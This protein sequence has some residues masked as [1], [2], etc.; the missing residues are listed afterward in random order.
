MTRWL[1]LIVI[2]SVV[3]SSPLAAQ[4]SS[5]TSGPASVEALRSLW[6]Q[7]TDYILRSAEQMPEE[8]YSYRPTEEVRSFGE[9]IAHVAGAQYTICAAALADP[10]REEDEIERTRTTKAELIEALRASTEYCER[11]YGQS[12]SELEGTTTLFD[13]DRTRRY[14][15]TLN[16]THNAQHYGNLVTYLRINGMVPPSSQ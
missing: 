14:A 1:R 13:R 6:V 12:D 5:T 16:T 7:I 4:S 9:M 11:A 8:N 3:G 2:T 15:I 10:P